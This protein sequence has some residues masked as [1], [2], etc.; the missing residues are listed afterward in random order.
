[1]AAMSAQERLQQGYAGYTPELQRAA[2]WIISHPAEAGLWS[3]RR[4]AEAVNVSPATMLRLA[5]AAGYDG[6]DALRQACQQALARKANTTLRERAAALQAGPELD[7]HAALTGLQVDAL[8]SVQQANSL[9][10]LDAAAQTMLQ[11]RLVGF[12]GTR[13]SFGIAFQMR[14]AYQLV[15][16]NGILIDG[17]GAMQ[18]EAADVLQAGDALVVISQAPY[19]ALTVQL[20]TELSAR[21]V[22]LIALTDSPLAPYTAQARHTLVFTPPDTGQAQGRPGSFFHTTAGLLGLAE[23]LVA[24]LAARGGPEV[25]TRLSAVET[26]L[27]ARRAYW[28]ATPEAGER[29]HTN[30][31][32]AASPSLS[33]D[34]P[35]SDTP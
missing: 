26:R 17:L 11:S 5:R 3:M 34:A 6:Y 1:M 14:Y 24:R 18:A 29:Q 15:R 30:A 25:L 20:A 13:S 35:F 16:S 33:S 12:L 7:G 23:H 22:A 8:R 4:Q 21:G 10:Q 31:A 32:H 27:R 9:A 19:P 2:R 28:R